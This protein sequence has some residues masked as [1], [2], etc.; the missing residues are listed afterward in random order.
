MNELPGNRGYFEIRAKD[1][2]ALG[3][4]SR[5]KKAVENTIFVYFYGPDGTTE[6]NPAPTDVKVKVGAADSDIVVALSPQ[7]QGGF[8]SA[9]GPFRSAFRGTLNAMIGGEP[10]EATFMIR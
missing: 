5:A 6:M 1:E 7:A 8:A 10:I 4:G 3:R 2:S 9:P